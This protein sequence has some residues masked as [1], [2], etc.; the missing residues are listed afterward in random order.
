MKKVLTFLLLLALIGACAAVGGVAERA[1]ERPILFT[2]YQ[3]MGWGDAFQAGFVDE[4]GGVW[5]LSGSASD[6]KWPG[7]L[8]AQ[9]AFLSGTDRLEKVGELDSEALFDLN[10]LIASAE[11]QPRE[12]RPAACDAGTEKS[13]ALR[14]GTD[15]E[16]EVVWLGMSGD[17]VFENTDPNAQALYLYLRRLFPNVTCYGGEMG[18]AGFQPVPVAQFLGIDASAVQGATV[19]AYLI[20]CEAGPVETDCDADRARAIVLDGT[21]TGKANATAVTGGTT[22]FGFYDA[23]GSCVAA[24]ELYRGLLVARDGMYTIE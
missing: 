12:A 16:A 19:K 7:T 8:E 24:F 14:Y 17:D 21:V 2:A 3:Q 13:V 15:G 20:D 18:P 22:S 9:L 23:N 1:T 11:A 4:A 5:T 6:V 10:G